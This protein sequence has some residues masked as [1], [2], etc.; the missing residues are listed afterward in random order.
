[1]LRS[2]G[3]SSVVLI[4]KS[5]FVPQNSVNG[6]ALLSPGKFFFVTE[7]KTANHTHRRLFTSQELL[8]FLL[9]NEGGVGAGLLLFRIGEEEEKLRSL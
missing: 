1:M 7:T 9:I 5:F 8:L 6:Y 2:I 3:G 4:V